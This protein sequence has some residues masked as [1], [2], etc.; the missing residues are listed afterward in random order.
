MC[1]FIFWTLFELENT[2][3]VK[4]CQE[5]LL[6]IVQKNLLGLLYVW[7]LPSYLTWVSK[8][9]ISEVQGHKPSSKY[10]ARFADQS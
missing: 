4:I 10:L 7:K 6:I 1:Q 3:N 5:N 8:F 9:D 2:I